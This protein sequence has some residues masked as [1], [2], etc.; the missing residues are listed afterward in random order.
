[1]KRMAVLVTLTALLV[2]MVLASAPGLP[3]AL[4]GY[5]NWTRLNIDRVTENPTGA[6]PQSKD[7][8]VNLEI[9]AL[10]FDDG[11]FQLPFADETFIIKERNDI[12]RLLADRLYVM[13]KREGQWQYSFYDRQADGSFSA[14]V[15]GTDNFCHDC[16]TGAEA[17]DYVF[18]RYRQR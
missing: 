1:M 2:G 8:Y 16:H 7:I 11:S 5:Q 17:T 18:T 9:D 15:L 13:E 14:Q 3:E 4:A 6:H 12:A 10:V